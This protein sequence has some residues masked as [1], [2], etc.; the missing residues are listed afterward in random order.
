M[1]RIVFITGSST[2][3]G[4]ETA[5]FFASKGWKV[6]ASMRHPES[7]KTDLAGKDN[8]DLIHLDVLDRSSISAAMKFTL[9]KYGRIDVV[10]NNAGYCLSG[11]FEASTREQ[12]EKEFNTNVLG[13]MEVTREII[14]VMRR[15]SGGVIINVASMA[16]RVAFPLYSVYNGTK[17]AVEG[18]SEGLQYELKPFNILVKII[19]PGIIKT[20]FYSRSMVVTDKGDLHLYDE[21]IARVNKNIGDLVEGGSEPKVVAETIYKAALDKSD[22][23]RYSVG[24]HARTLLLL[25]KI[26]PESLFKR[27]LRHTALKN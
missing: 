18:F 15:Q 19:E 10:V 26:L 8:I 1:D 4:R 14:P 23:L 13:L 7:R 25:R 3:I 6:V 21:F 27:I 20:D 16:G 12:I 9:D 11:P 2:G 5:L 17:W 24:S 22:K